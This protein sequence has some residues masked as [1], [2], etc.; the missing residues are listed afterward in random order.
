MQ[1]SVLVTAVQNYVRI[2]G[3]DMLP[4]IKDFINESIIEFVRLRDWRMLKAFDTITTDGTGYYDLPDDFLREI[5]LFSSE[6]RYNKREY[7]GYV[8]DQNKTYLYSVFGDKIYVDGTGAS[9]TFLYLSKG[10]PY[11]LSA[12]A[13]ESDVVK[14]YADVIKQWT[15]WKMMDYWVDD[16]GKAREQSRLKILLDELIKSE[17]RANQAGQRPIVATFRR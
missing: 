4:V 13:D 11:P 6:M 9:L 3:T 5:D 10:D 8:L 2:T 7:S 17:N 16:A 12:D 15:L 1:F 14:Y